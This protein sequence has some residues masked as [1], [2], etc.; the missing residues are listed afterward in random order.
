MKNFKSKISTLFTIMLIILSTLGICNVLAEEE[1]EAKEKFGEVIIESNHTHTYSNGSYIPYSNL[2]DYYDVFCCQKG[3]AL[4][5]DNQTEVAVW[6]GKKKEDPQGVS[7]PYLTQNDKGKE[8]LRQSSTSGSPFLHSTYTN[9][10]IGQYKITATKI[11]TPKEAYI[12]S[13]MIK[14]D[15]MGEYNYAQYAWW[16]TEA[17]SKGNTVAENAFAKEADAFEA[18]ILQVAGVTS[19]S[20]LKYKTAEFTTENGEHKSYEN[21]FDF[22]YDPKWVTE[23]E[24]QTP[25]VTWDSEAQ[26]YTIG[27]FAIDYVG[28]AEQFTGETDA[29]TEGEYEGQTVKFGDRDEVQFAGITDM[30]LFTDASEEPLEFGKD[31]EF[32]WI[33]GERTPET[34]SEYPL[35]NEKFYIRLN[36][37]DDVTKIT[38]IKTKFKYMN[39][40]GV[41]QDL[42]GTYFKATWK[43]KS[44]DYTTTRRTPSGR[45]TQVYD[46]T[47]YWLKL[48]SLEEYPSQ[49]LALGINAARWY[50]YMELDRRLEIRSGKIR[51]E[52]EVVDNEGNR[53]EDV[54]KFFN[55]KVNVDGAL[56]GGS[57]V[58]RVRANGAA[59][60]KVYYWMAESGTPTYSVQEIPEEGYKQVEIKNETGS[61]SEDGA[62]LVKAINTGE[63]TGTLQ[64]VKQAEKFTLNDKEADLEG[65]TFNFK[66]TIS[67][68]FEYAGTMYKDASIIVDAATT[69]QGGTGIWNLGEVKWYGDTAPQYKVEELPSEDA[70][71]VELIASTGSLVE[72]ETVTAIAINRQKI[73]K[74]KLHIIKTLENANLYSEEE[75]MKLKFNFKIK[76]DGYEEEYVTLSAVRKEND[77]VWEFTSGY[78]E[79]LKGENP[80][81]T[82][83]EVDLPKGTEF[84]SAESEEGSA[85]GD[86]IQGTLKSDEEKEYEV[87][88]KFI[89]KANIEHTGKIE[90]TKKVDD[91]T[92]VDKDYK[93][94]VTVSGTFEYKGTQYKDQTIQLTN[95]SAVV[96]EGSKYDE[97]NFVIIHVDSSKT[98][99]WTSDEFKWYGEKSPQYNVEENLLGEDIIDSIEPSKGNLGDEDGS[100]KVTAW[101]RLNADSGYLHI[102]KTLEDADKFSV[103]YVKNLVFKFRVKVDGY[104][105]Y[106]VAL[107]AEKKGNS[108]VWEYTS[109][110]FT[111]E[112]NGTPLNYEIEEIDIPEGTEFVS[113]TSDG[114]TVSGTKIS[115]Q[116]KK[117][118]TGEVLIVTE[119]SFIN[120]AKENSGNLKIDKRVTHESLN[121]KEFKFKV[122]L[123]GAFEY[124]GVTYGPNSGNGEELVIDNVVVTGGTVWD[125]GTIK[126]YGTEAPTY[127]VE[128]ISKESEDS[129]EKDISTLGSVL[130]ASGTIKNGANATIATFTN[131]PKVVSGYLQI[132]KQIENGVATDDEFTFEI[133]I[134]KYEKPFIVKIKANE[135]YKLALKWNASEEAPKYKVEEKNIPKGATLVRIDNGEG[136]LEEGKTVSVVA[137]NKYEEH[138][139]TFSVKKEIIADEKLLDGLD[140]PSFDLTITISG[141]FEMNGESVVNSTRVITTSLKGGETYTSPS[142][143]WWGNNV[144][145]ATVVENNVPKGWKN[146][147]ISNNGAPIS[148]NLEIVVTNRLETITIIDLTFKLAGDVWED[149]AQDPDS[150]NTADSVANGK[151]DESEQGLKGVE[152][153]IYDGE[154]NLA[155]IYDDGAEISQPIITSDNG[156]WEAP[157]VKVLKSGA[158]DVEFVYDGQT[159]EPTKFL[160]TSEGNA[161]SYKSATTSGRDAWAKDSMALDYNREEVNA[162]LEKIKGGTPIDGTG[163]TVGTVEG[164]E[165][166][167]D[168]YYTS[169]STAIGDSQRRISKVV[170]TNANGRAKDVFKAKARTS[171]GGLT[172]PF[173]N[174]IH[175]ESF[176]TYISEL[177]LVQYYTYSATYNYTLHINLGL[178]KRPEADLGAT[179]DLVSANV[180]VNNRLLKYKFNTLDD[181]G[182]DCYSRQLYADTNKIEYELG[183]YKT[184]YYYRAEIYQ[185]S[186]NTE[187]YD[188]IEKFYK[189]LNMKI[190][191]TELEVYLMYKISLYNE[192]ANYV[193]QINAVDDYFDTSLGKPVSE[194]IEKYIKSEDGMV[195]VANSS[196]I[197]VGSGSQNQVN[198]NITEK[199]IR[200]SDGITYNKMT[201]ELDNLKL[202]SGERADIFVT[203]KVQKD[204]INGVQNAV[205][206]GNKS[207]VVEISNYSTYNSDGSLAGKVDRDSA[208]GNVNIRS[209][210]VT[211]WYE[212]DTFA[213]PVLELKLIEEER[214]INGKAWEDKAEGDSAVGNGIYDNNEALIGGL[215]TELI[216]K[217][218]VKGDSGYIEYDFLW[219]T[220]KGLD[221]LGGK[222]ME[223]LTGFDSTTETARQGIDSEEEKVSVGEYKFNGVPVG[224]YVVRFLYGNNKMK[225]EDTHGITGEAVALKSDGSSFSG[226]DKILIANYDN[227]TVGASSI[228]NGQDFKA[229]IY[230]AGFVATDSN[231]YINNEWHD[232]DNIAL[233]EAKVSDARDNEARRLGVISNSE[234]I[235][236]INGKVLKTANDVEEKHTELY[237][238]YSMFADT[239]KLKLEIRG[240]GEAAVQ[241]EELK[242]TII[243]NGSVKVTEEEIDYTIK[244][245]DCG[246]IER[247]KT[248]LVL[249]KEISSI[250]LTTNDGRTIFNAM[251]DID[252]ELKS[253]LFGSTADKVVV[254]KIDNKYLIAS[255]K[256]NEASVGTDL[257]QAID[258]NEN[259]L[260]DEGITGTK[261]FRFINIDDTILQGTT[262]ELN[263]LISALNVG[264]VDMTS[265]LLENEIY[266]TAKTNGTTVKDEIAILSQKAEEESKVSSSMDSEIK[267]GQY[268][269]TTYYTG[270]VGSD[271]VV[272]T[273][274]RQVVEYVDN[275][276][277]FSPE[278]NKEVDHSWKNTSVTELTGNGYRADRLLDEVITTE[279]ELI[280]INNIAYINKQRNNVVLSIDT[281]AI[282]EQQELHNTGFETKLLPYAQDENAYKSSIQLTV[283]KTVSAQDDANSLTYDNVAEIVKFENSVG[284]R[285]QVAIPGNANPKLGEFEVALNE[286]DSSATELVTFTPPT[287]IEAHSIISIQVLIVIV[288]SLVI[289]AVGIV[290]IKKKVLK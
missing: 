8:I 208:A 152:V 33:E 92:L 269:G 101:N 227:D 5:S 243:E 107:K 12:L 39:A 50:E 114:G 58:I 169:S 27:P 209:Y 54:D 89:N 131:E 51:I 187:G 221:A 11:A 210:N 279:N 141:T 142:I 112:K 25:T 13:E 98:T 254:G 196:Y 74:A 231:G 56:N 149:V 104:E 189:D 95:D 133:T 132:T 230:Q 173:D 172:Y 124:N 203:F 47:D 123:R 229:T 23:G 30:Q 246:L 134:D 157:S 69:I 81:Y 60:S 6:N 276:G 183:L 171:K 280:D 150:K 277:I 223:Y 249:D 154:G 213:A 245:I 3:T 174:R 105:P 240:Y 236:N 188:S 121:G 78:Y 110:A 117:S 151:I 185:A 66:V 126:W 34:E 122:T 73:E 197:T 288:A 21:A 24:Y 10:T 88:N 250:K 266:E 100:I 87:I 9:K 256:L 75:I 94:V 252:Y 106:V 247:P 199:G 290:I 261:N 145:T 153:Y 218:K 14:V 53:V 259:K 285:D 204:N 162:R 178:T 108:Y 90:L 129:E 147:G 128:E 96:L 274:V 61:L 166:E 260:E 239:A 282:P 176:D 194:K 222:T 17:G 118:K 165:G 257:M 263:Y 68:T 198:W 116:L 32:V 272:T 271:Q 99:T 120:K 148:D 59:L 19:T 1:Q 137:I 31:W 181:I 4:P 135:T 241:K 43:E 64:I 136:S 265:N 234:L 155:K 159:Y 167:K 258:K 170:T 278:Y 219:P 67:G 225:L 200:G 262:I 15:G 202:Q 85:T 103:D 264:E 36:Y 161:D 97:E 7:F 267:L 195:E 214:K 82:I 244:D 237:E 228:Y 79:W 215:T 238:D 146:I 48:T 125:S 193:A 289:V 139:G 20:E 42:Q 111:W 22:E 2:N 175:L 168:I 226:N 286:R 287:G 46:H 216:E 76:V 207:N 205:A 55:F 57:D 177:G 84:V 242:G 138:Q 37:I 284:R 217:V 253:D 62:V 35:A 270:N 268:L 220:N 28:S 77:Y 115:G 251:Y 127:T 192:S 160:A 130:N 119:N 29:E 49:R 184:D 206:L 158:Y 180:V 71:L 70:D 281:E 235:T 16:T 45:L 224:D 109:D 211:E 44:K 182:S 191:D 72:N 255:V 93:F 179:K 102:I 163:N 273:R 201:A 91:D 65:K 41:Y 275:D 143:K 140:M 86:G 283:T 52:K 83:T 18:Y 113:A 233:A 186:G 232:L 40:C 190:E 164:S 248:K 212:D 156:H 144:P 26:K 63:H 80:E 38:N